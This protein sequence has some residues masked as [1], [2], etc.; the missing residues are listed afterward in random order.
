MGNAKVTCKLIADFLRKQADQLEDQGDSLDPI[1]KM[2]G[3]M[4]LKQGSDDQHGNFIP[5]IALVFL[6]DDDPAV[7]TEKLALL[8]GDDDDVDD[9]TEDDDY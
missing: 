4:V 8:D 5:S 2:S 9:G 1:L 3:Q 7:I 6:F